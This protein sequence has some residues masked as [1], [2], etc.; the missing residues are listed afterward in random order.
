MPSCSRASLRARYASYDIVASPPRRCCSPGWRPERSA[1]RI[2]VVPNDVPPPPPTDFLALKL[3]SSMAAKLR[4]PD[5]GAIVRCRRLAVV[6]VPDDMPANAR[7]SGGD[8]PVNI[9]VPPAL[10][11]ENADDEEDE[12]PKRVAPA[13]GKAPTPGGAEVDDEAPAV[14]PAAAVPILNVV[15]GPGVVA[16]FTTADDEYKTAH[17]SDKRSSNSFSFRCVAACCSRRSRE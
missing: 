2:V 1:P 8:A 11:P 14:E 9:I 3:R 12:P 5:D 7:P 16:A 10:A 17:E 4:R 6:R 15:A 13:P